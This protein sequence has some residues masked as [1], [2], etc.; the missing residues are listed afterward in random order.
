MPSGPRAWSASMRPRSGLLG[1]A[2]EIGPDVDTAFQRGHTAISTM[3]GAL[4]LI[5][6]YLGLKRNDQPLRLAGFA[7]FGVSLAKIFL[8]DLSRLDSVTRA[9]S[10]LAVGGVLLLAGFSYQRLN[11]AGKERNPAPSSPP[12]P[13]R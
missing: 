2:Q 12:D 4:G 6:L 7:V 5:A 10:F 8:Y 11:E 9:L 3:W 13:T 1:L